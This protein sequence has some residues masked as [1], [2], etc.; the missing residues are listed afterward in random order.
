M[1][2]RDRSRSFAVE[3]KVLIGKNPDDVHEAGT[4]AA[5]ITT[6]RPH[7]ALLRRIAWIDQLAGPWISRSL[8][9]LLDGLNLGA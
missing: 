4:A 9:D 7:A 5:R 6:K 1:P 8:V 3:R 2:Y